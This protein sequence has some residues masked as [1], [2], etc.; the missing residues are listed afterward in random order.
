[1]TAVTGEKMMPADLVEFNKAVLIP[2]ER[3]WNML[4]PGSE[5]KCE[6]GKSDCSCKDEDVVDRIIKILAK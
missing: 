3:T 5:D 4:Q 2:L 6:C 1:M